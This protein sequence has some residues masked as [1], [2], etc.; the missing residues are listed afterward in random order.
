M[1]NK[2]TE[3]GG[4]LRRIEQSDVAKECIVCGHIEYEL[5]QSIIGGF[6]GCGIMACLLILILAVKAFIAIF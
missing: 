2:C 5:D 4:G 3:C 6:Y 1:I